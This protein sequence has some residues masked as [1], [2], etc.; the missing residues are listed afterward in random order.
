MNDELNPLLVDDLLRGCRSGSPSSSS[1]LKV[2]SI[3]C[4]C[5]RFALL[6]GCAAGVC[7]EEGLEVGCENGAG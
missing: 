2:K 6:A 3:T 7:V 5:F 1:L 4:G